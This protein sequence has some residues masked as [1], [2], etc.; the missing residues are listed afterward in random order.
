VV[1]GEYP[2][3]V[4]IRN[5]A[6]FG[7]V[8]DINDENEEDHWQSF[9]A[10]TL[11]GIVTEALAEKEREVQMYLAYRRDDSDAQQGEAD[12]YKVQPGEKKKRQKRL[13]GDDRRTGKTLRQPHQLVVVDGGSHLQSRM[14]GQSTSWQR[15][16]ISAMSGKYLLGGDTNLLNLLGAKFGA[17]LNLLTRNRERTWRLLRAW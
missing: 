14:Q 12:C 9:D 11:V 16:Q 10:K 2:L 6:T 7:Y 13:T 15:R 5:Y 3:A 4:K 8:E 17:T 1:L